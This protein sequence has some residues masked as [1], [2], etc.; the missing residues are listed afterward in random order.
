MEISMATIRK[1]KGKR[2]V[3]YQAQ[4]RRDGHP[5]QCRTFRDRKAAEQWAR[6]IE[7]AADRDILPDLSLLKTMTVGDLARRY[8]AEL[9]IRK[10]SETDTVVIESLLRTDLAL[11][12]LAITT[13]ADF[14]AHRE[15]RLLVVCP[16]TVNRELTPLKHMFNVAKEVWG[17]PVTNPVTGLFIEGADNPRDIRLLEEDEDKLLR[18]AQRARNKLIV[19]IVLFALETAMRRGEILNMRWR[20]IL[21]KEPALLIPETKTGRSRTIPLS[22]PAL[23]ILNS[24]RGESF[25]PDAKVFPISANAMRL[26]FERIRKRA[27]LLH[28]HFHDL[29]HEAISRLFERGLN[30]PEVALITGHKSYKML[31]RY[32]HPQRKLIAAKLA[33]PLALPAP[34]QTHAVTPRNLLQESPSDGPVMVSPPA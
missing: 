15:Q 26:S 16:A 20:D 33:A 21:W 12:S 29:R 22:R 31:A 19:A 2:G 32:T 7:A 28:L 3:T 9:C 13:K 30:M 8:L 27:G 4:V 10:R 25:D 18:A 11:K 23:A 5:K 1:R 34:I 17:I 14:A 24:G 6:Q